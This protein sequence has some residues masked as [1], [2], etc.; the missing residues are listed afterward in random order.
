MA[1]TNISCEGDRQ[2]AETLGMLAKKRRTTIGRLVRIA[3]DTAYGSDLAQVEQAAAIFF[4]DGCASEFS[5]E[6]EST[7]A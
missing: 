7:K 6:L 3:I 5:N 2:F 1:T 4:A